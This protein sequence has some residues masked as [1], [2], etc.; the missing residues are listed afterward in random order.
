MLPIP[1]ATP[2]GHALDWTWPWVVRHHSPVLAICG[3]LLASPIVTV[4][5][6]PPNVVLIL[7]DDLGWSDLGCYG[8][9]LHHTP[10]LDRL[11][12]Q[13]RRF[14]EGYAPAPICSASRAALQTGRSPARLGFEFVVKEPDAP[15]LGGHPLTP[16]PYPVELP[17][18]EVTMGEVLGPAGYVTGFYGKWHLAQHYQTYL[19]WS[20]TAG[21]FQQGY[22]EG[23]MDFG[24]HP[25]GEKTRPPSE[26]GF[27]PQG[28]YGRDALTDL[29]IGFL[30]EHRQQP[31]FLQLCHYYVHEPVRSRAQ[32]LV[33]KYAAR[34]PAGTP[35]KRAVYA[36]MVETLDHLVGQLLHALDELGLADNTLV[37]FTSDNG[38]NPKYAANG[39]LRGGKWGLYEG[40]LRVPWIVRWPGHVPAG[41]TSDIPIIGTD[42]LPTLSAVAGADLPKGIALD[43]MNDLPIWCG[44]VKR[45]ADRAFVWHFPYY[46]PE[47]DFEAALPKSGVNDFALSQNRPQSAIR[48]GDW[49]LIHFY[50]SA[51]DELYR[52]SSDRSQQRDLS[53]SEPRKARELRQRLDDYLAQVNARLP[54]PVSPPVSGDRQTHQ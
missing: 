8:N 53:A 11:A 2:L 45:E 46:H 19:G 39:P 35:P 12:T 30:R 33:D 5:A 44:D 28:D 13:G 43:G 38:G 16:P 10:N 14:T 24:S 32:W 54:S 23:S 41:T 18:S 31:F 15:P 50:E 7:V 49:V 52:L 25:Y 34:L 4:S 37:V 22:A 40:G 26:R 47:K 21:P 42:L 9:P 20:P 29:A 48:L 36:A 6:A 51:R 3:A 1:S 17:L 27:L